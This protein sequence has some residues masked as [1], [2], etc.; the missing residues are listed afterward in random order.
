MP[1][2]VEIRLTSL[3]VILS[4]YSSIYFW[5]RNCIL[6]IF[7]IL[8]SIFLTCFV[9]FK[10]KFT[11][12]V[13]YLSSLLF[14]VS[15]LLVQVLAV[16]ELE[17]VKAYPEKPLL[18]QAIYITPIFLIMLLGSNMLQSWKVKKRLDG[19]DATLKRVEE[20]QQAATKEINERFEEI[21]ERFDEQAKH[22]RCVTVALNTLTN[23]MLST[24]PRVLPKRR[25][26]SRF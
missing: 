11:T 1:L 15:S 2:E 5:H 25:G 4:L 6:F 12:F 10:D 19:I 7:P 3:V 13:P 20:Q 14:S 26:S 9:L 24:P 17:S 18:E 21:N 16:V 8:A 23:A 22:N